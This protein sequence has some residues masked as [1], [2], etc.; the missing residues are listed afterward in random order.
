VVCVI[1]AAPS[2]AGAVRLAHPV[3]SSLVLAALALVTIAAYVGTGRARCS[4][5]C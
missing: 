2:D 4:P 1:L 5:S 3:A